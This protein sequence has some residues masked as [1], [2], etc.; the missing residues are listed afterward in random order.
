MA[1]PIGLVAR[2]CH[3]LV[4][5]RDFLYLGTPKRVSRM[6]AFWRGSEHKKYDNVIRHSGYQITA[7]HWLVGVG[8]AEN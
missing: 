4:V 6:T 1:T 7:Q 5:L 2:L 3:R 8:K